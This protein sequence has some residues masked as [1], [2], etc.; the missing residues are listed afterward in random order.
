[1]KKSKLNF[2]ICKFDDDTNRVFVAGIVSR[3]IRTQRTETDEN[4]DS[5]TIELSCGSPGVPGIYTKV[6]YHHEWILDKIF[7]FNL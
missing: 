5:I 3:G 4:G 6:I 2:K 1:M 7:Q